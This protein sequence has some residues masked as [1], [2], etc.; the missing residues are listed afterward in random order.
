M[1]SIC[2]ACVDVLLQYILVGHISLLSCVVRVSIIESLLNTLGNYDLL[3]WYELFPLKVL[4]NV[5][6]TRDY[7]K[8][9]WYKELVPTCHL[10]SWS[11]GLCVSIC[12]NRSKHEALAMV[13][14]CVLCHH[15]YIQIEVIQMCIYIIYAVYFLIIYLVCGYV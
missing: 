8:T 2:A 12:W 14:Q 4:V 1:V 9:H 15:R 6:Q 13:V 7:E 5:I 11:L 10:D 3:S